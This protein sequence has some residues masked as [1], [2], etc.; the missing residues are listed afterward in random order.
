M[1]LRTPPSWLQNGSHPA[2]N[3]RLSMQGIIATTGI[4]GTSSLA[5]TQAGTPGM[6]VQVATGWGAIVGDFTTNMGVYQFYNDAAT[7]LSITAANPT[8]P[9]IDRVVVTVNDS[10]YTGATNNVTFTVV[11][12]TPAA[13]PSAPATPTN[14]IS[15]ATIAVAAGATSILNANI[16]DT[17]VSVTTNL[18]VGDLTEV[19]AGTG[20]TVASGTGPIPIVS[21]DATV[22]SGYTTTVTAGGTTTLTAASTSTQFF[23]GTSTQTITLPVVST[24][25]LGEAYAIH[26]NSTGALTVNSSGGN[27]VVTIPAGNTYLITCILTTGTTAASWDADFTGTSTVTGTGANVLAISPTITTPNIS[28]IINTGTLTLPTSTGTVAL[29]NGVINNTLTTTTGDIIYASSANTPARLGIGSTSQVLTV[30]GG[31]PTWSTISAGGM[32]VIASGNLTGTSITISSIPQTYNNLQLVLRGLQ[33]TGQNQNA[34]LRFNSDTGTNYF[35]TTSNGIN[36]QSWNATLIELGNAQDNTAG[37]SF[38]VTDLYDYTNTS[39][40]KATSTIAIQN[41]ATSPTNFDIARELGFWYASNGA[42]AI[43]SIL[44]FTQSSGFTAGTYTLYGVK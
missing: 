14:S 23:T 11:A 20:I 10:Y 21:V 7:Q 26:N 19:Q 16:T 38:L 9:R 12:G 28:S 4:I 30:S 13:S 17:R 43:T 5:V 40:W 31:L 25:I 22:I 18:P 15:L 37:Q 29:T 42:S 24:L 44:I 6:A 2:E 8:N 35:K 34:R 39:S 1:A 3:D 33:P 27:L 32:T 36:L 41:R